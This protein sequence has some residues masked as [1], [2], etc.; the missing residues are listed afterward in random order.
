[1]SGVK[2]KVLYSIRKKGRG[3]VFCA[4][5]FLNIAHRNTLDKLLYRLE[6]QEIIRNI[7]WGLY[8]YPI[9][10]KEGKLEEPNLNAVIKAIE[11]QFNDS[12]QYSGQ[13][14]AYLLGLIDKPDKIT[15]L[16]NKRKRQLEIRCYNIKINK[17][18]IISPKN[19]NDKATIATQALIWIGKEGITNELLIDVLTQLNM[20]EKK[21][22]RMLLKSAPVWLS[23][24]LSK[25]L[26]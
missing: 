11:V 12:L 8:D 17:T 14:S 20:K 26:L 22:L 3:W 24:R 1:M 23:N 15:Y 5:N 13:Y 2:E 25:T 6:Q 7:N 10:N 16:S 21:K 9:V 18:A 19:K 4:K